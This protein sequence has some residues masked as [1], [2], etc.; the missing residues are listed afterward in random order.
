MV[1]GGRGRGREGEGEGERGG[2]L[3]SPN[4][5]KKSPDSEVS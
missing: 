3:T 2:N 5:S 4:T 1:L